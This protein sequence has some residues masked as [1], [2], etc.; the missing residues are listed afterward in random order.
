MMTAA[1]AGTQNNCVEQLST[2]VSVGDTCSW[3][4]EQRGGSSV[5]RKSSIWGMEA[6]S[7]SSGTS[8]AEVQQGCC[9]SLRIARKHS[10]SLA[11]VNAMLDADALAQLWPNALL[12]A[13]PPLSLISPTLARVREQ[14]L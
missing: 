9:R 11:D 4:V 14:G 8:V 6:P 13:F 5:Q 10:V 2:R 12:Y 3:S 7:P 1:Q